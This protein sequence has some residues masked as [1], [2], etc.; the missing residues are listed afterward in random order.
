VSH[1][2]LAEWLKV[3]REKVR[4]LLNEL[5]YHAHTT[6][7]ELMGTADI[8]EGEL[9]SG[10]M[11]LSQN[12]D[13]NPAR[14]VEYLS[15][16]AGLLLPH[17]V[18]VYTFPHRTFQEYLAACYLTDHDYP[19]LVAGLARKGPDRWREVAL[20]AGAKAGRGTASAIWLL[21]E[22]LCYREPEAAESDVA[23][24]WG[25]HLAGQA[26]TET[27]DLARVSERDQ[28]KVQR[29]RRWLV[30]ILHG[31]ELPAVERAAAGDTLARLGDPRFK[32][33]AR[34]LPGEPLLGFIEIPPGPLLMGTR[35]GDIP[36][37]LKRF[38]GSREW[39][40]REIPQHEI[41]LPAYYIA[42]YPVTVAQ[43]RAF[44]QESQYEAQGP[45][46]RY[47][48]LSNHPVVAVTWYDARAYCDWLT[49]QLRAWE[50]T[51][52]PLVRLLR[53]EDWV[54]RLPTEAEWEKAAR[55][56]DGRTYPWGNEPDADRANYADAGIGSTS[57]VGC[58]PGGASPYEVLDMSGNVYEWC[59][60]LYKSY[61]YDPRDGREDTKATG[62]RVLRG[63]AFNLI[64]W[65]VRCAYRLRLNPYYRSR[66]VGFRVVV[67]PGF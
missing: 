1:P 63:G 22:G 42:R 15:Q 20:L 52:G 2:S 31:G 13:V 5:A 29:V 26:L 27:A 39:Y 55:G 23:D 19:D 6:Q 49:G 21:V 14:V 9:V 28:G 3:D 4:E 37:L 16:R 56:T 41:T 54:V 44:V 25:A 43:Y 33:D 46:E 45:W 10:L 30:H 12:P 8:P 7:P 62:H 67:A 35:E 57:A 32:A 34:Y 38:G 51:P 24:A 60:S 66:R 50:G 59:R 18:G 17:G 40:E 53:E 48:S 47:G 36:T 58:F 61:P 64:E 65:F 11:R